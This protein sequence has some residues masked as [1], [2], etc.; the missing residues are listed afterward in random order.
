M[1]GNAGYRFKYKYAYYYFVA[2]YFSKNL[3][4][5]K[6]REQISIMC[7]KLHIEENANIIMFLTHMSKDPYIFNEVL[8][9]AQ[10][11]FKGYEPTKLQN[12]ISELNNLIGNIPEI[13]YEHIE[14]KQHREEQLLIKDEIERSQK[15]TASSAIEDSY[16]NEEKNGLDLVATLNS[17]FKTIEIIGQILKNYYG[18]IKGD[19]K[20]ILCSEAYNIGLRSLGSFLTMMDQHISGI[21]QEIQRIIEE[22]NIVD[23]KDID[24]ISRKFVFNIC[25]MI[26][27]NVIKKVSNSVGS[28]NLVGTFKKLLNDNDTVSV[29]LIDISIKLDH[30]RTIPF[31]EIKDLNNTLKSNLLPYNILR[32]LV[33]NHLYMFHTSYKDKQRICD[34]LDI[35]VGKQRSIE[36]LSHRKKDK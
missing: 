31:N 25:C 18:S 36:L 8:N 3:T 6:T 10:N 29:K 20:Y 12:E 27:Y 7:G 15:E 35:S 21:I 30:L 28:D 14:V 11:I 16:D 1:G 13:V 4:E 26:S 23:K 19:E 34:L 33:V 2:K 5:L 24:N 9:Q 17:A 22:K 32:G